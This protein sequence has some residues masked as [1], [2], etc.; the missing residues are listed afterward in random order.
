MRVST[1]GTRTARTH[2]SSPATTWGERQRLSSSFA[3]ASADSGRSPDGPLERLDE[4][5]DLRPDDGELRLFAAEAHARVGRFDAARAQLAAAK[6]KTKRTSWLRQEAEIE[7][8]AG[9]PGSAMDSWRSVLEEEPLAIDAHTAIANLL[10]ATEGP[11]AAV[12]HLDAAGERFPYHQEL[13]RL[14]LASLR[15]QDP[16]RAVELAGRICEHHPEDA[17]TRKERA[18]LLQRLGRTAEAFAE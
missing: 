12:A 3:N 7:G 17:W 4:A 13:Q 8:Y 10:A 5:L 15:Q 6:G 1:K 14:R 11:G 18:L 2:T 16:Q 9:A